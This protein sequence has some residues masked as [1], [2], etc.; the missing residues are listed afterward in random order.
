MRATERRPV[1]LAHLTALKL[2]PAR[3][4]ALAARAGYQSVS[5]RLAPVAPGAVHY[6]L[7]PGTAA[8][9]AARDAMS[10]CGI[11]VSGV[12]IL[13]LGP[14][15]DIALVEPLLARGAELGAIGLCVTGDDPVR[16]RIVANF[17]RLCE[18]AYA[19]KINVDLEFMRWRDI[20]TLKDAAAVVTAAN[21]PNGFVLLDTLH[22]I[23]SGGSAADVVS[24]DA[25]LFRCVQL[26]DAHAEIPADLDVIGE[27]RSGRLPVG[28]GALPLASV[29]SALPADV[30]LSAELPINARNET[31]LTDALARSRHEIG[32]LT[33]DIARTRPAG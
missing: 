9:R 23:R 20:A 28:D 30:A 11:T 17:A 33:A 5:L 19:Y 12:E 13:S 22:L 32:R 16:N 31:A 21:A 8:L 14:D 26:S 7:Q 3:F 27:A 2:H 25:R 4:A 24:A 15:F 18:L 29:V 1:E 6:S 10:D